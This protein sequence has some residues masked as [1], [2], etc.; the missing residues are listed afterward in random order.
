VAKPHIDGSSARYASLYITDHIHKPSGVTSR[1]VSSDMLRCHRRP[2]AHNA[3]WMLGG[4]GANLLLQ[5]AFFI[6]L[7]RFLGV[8]QYGIFAGA[9]ALIS[10]VTPYSTLGSAM[11]FMRYVTG[12]EGAAAVY[13]GNSL[14][15]TAVVSIGLAALFGYIGPVITGAHSRL[16]FVALALAN[17]LFGQIVGLASSIFQTFE[18]MRP[19]AILTLLANGARLLV[20]MVMQRM[21]PHASAMQWS[22]GVLIASFGAAML[23]LG[24]VWSQIGQPQFS[25]RLIWGRVREGVGFSFAGTTQAV[26]NDIDKTMLSHFGFNRENGSYTLAYRI[27]DVATAPIVAM[28]AAILPRYFHLSHQG[29]QAVGRLAVKALSMALPL[30]LVIGIGT[31]L[32]APVVPRLVGRDFS[33]TLVALRWLCW[34]P[35][36]RGVHMLTGSALTGAGHQNLR[37]IAQLSVAAANI[38]LNVWWINRFGWI[39]AAWSSVVCDGLLAIVNA[40]ILLWLWKASV[41]SGLKDLPETECVT[42]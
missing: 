20:L 5:V 21:F 19:A 40:S 25:A 22:V 41:V 6:L 38:V 13:W 27:V 42:R 11:L 31:L 1:R 14:A 23:S 15:I 30:G 9:F 37:T 29:V 18:N 28:D 2:L 32:V 17:C 34:L 16:L 33:L 4:Q 24:W 3:S 12:D 7:A 39:G 35:L 36:L 26:Y 10:M 8:T